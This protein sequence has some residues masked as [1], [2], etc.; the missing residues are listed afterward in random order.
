MHDDL[1]P[2]RRKKRQDILRMEDIDSMLKKI[3][4]QRKEIPDKTVLGRERDDL[5]ILLSL[6]P[7]P[8]R[9]RSYFF[10][11]GLVGQQYVPILLVQLQHLF[12]QVEKRVRFSRR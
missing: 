10:G 8:E 5:D 11:L 7:E 3:F 1:R 2:A 12:R 9:K 6:A 4:R